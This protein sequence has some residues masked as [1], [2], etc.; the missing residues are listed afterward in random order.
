MEA[1][2]HQNLAT[3]LILEEPELLSESPGD[4]GFLAEI[5]EP[6]STKPTPSHAP[7]RAFSAFDPIAAFQELKATWA[8][9]GNSAS[10]KIKI[11]HLAQSLV[12]QYPAYLDQ[13]DLDASFKP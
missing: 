1:A 7:T 2:R 3:E 12:K 4:M 5:P 9:P 13:R 11:R 10:Q 8:K 6:P